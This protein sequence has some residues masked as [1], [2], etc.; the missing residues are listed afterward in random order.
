MTLHRLG[1]INVPVKVGPRAWLRCW[2]VMAGKTALF[3]VNESLSRRQRLVYAA[4][5]RQRR[6][7]QYALWTSPN[8]IFF[9]KETWTKVEG[10]GRVVKLHDAGPWA[11]RWPGYSAAR[12][13]TV[14]VFER[15]DGTQHA[16]VNAHLVPDGSKV[17]PRW[18]SKVRDSSFVQ[19]RDLVDGLT[20]LGCI[21][22]LLGDMNVYP[23]FQMGD[24]F[25]WV[26]GHGIDKLGVSLPDGVTLGDGGWELINA[27]TDHQHGLVARVHIIKEK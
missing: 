20:D 24:R 16:V 9:A 26:R 13:A 14:C 1:V 6:W 17:E 4:A 23:E 12:Y 7:G 10:S 19:L 11:G 22:W 5:M 3:G 8:P 18:R 25:H 15:N 2:R 27:P 21:T